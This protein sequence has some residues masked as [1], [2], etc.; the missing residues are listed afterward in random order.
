[1]PDGSLRLR[2]LVVLVPVLMPLSGASAQAPSPAPQSSRLAIVQVADNFVIRAAEASRPAH[3]TLSLG[4]SV[5]LDRELL[6]GS[7]SSRTG[8]REGGRD[9]AR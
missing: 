9:E 1:M 7:A 3:G 8:T 5:H 4:R 6:A 2:V